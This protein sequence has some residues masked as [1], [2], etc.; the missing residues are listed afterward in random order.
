MTKIRL[1]LACSEYDRTAALIS[2]DIEPEGISLNYLRLPVEEIFWRMIKHQEFDVSEMSFSSYM[3]HRSRADDFMA[4]PVFPSRFFRHSCI[5]INARAGIE[6]PEDLVGKRV[7][8]PEYQMTASLWQRALLQHEYGVHP[9]ALRWFQGGLEEPGRV[10]KQTINLPTEIDIQPIGPTQTLSQML[11]D[12]EIDALLSAHAPSSFYDNDINAMSSNTP[13]ISGG[14]GQVRRLFPNYKEVEQAYFKKTGIFPIM[15][16]I[17]LR[18]DVLE[19]HPWAARS[20]YKAFSLAKD[21]LFKQMADTVVLRLSLP[22]LFA[23]LEETVRLMGSDF[24]PYGVEANIKTL[25]A[26]TLYSHEQGLTPHKL[27]VEELFVPGT[28][29]EFKI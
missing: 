17:V 10:E 18:K 29:D 25:E 15:H 7:G 27:D 22:W 13:L 12:G 4:I 19:K 8:V 6:R 24:W 14:N 20:F 3:I 21:Q 23:E 26:A 11:K 28:I 2:G 5:F 16:V 1:T 9:S